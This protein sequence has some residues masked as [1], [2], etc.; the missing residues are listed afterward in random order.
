MARCVADVVAAAG[1]PLELCYLIRLS[2]GT[3][4]SRSEVH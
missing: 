1:V 3:A 2:T 4:N